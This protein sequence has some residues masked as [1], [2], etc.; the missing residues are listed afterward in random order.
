MKTTADAIDRLCTNL[1][2]M[3]VFLGVMLLGVIWAIVDWGPGVQ[4][5]INGE[6]ITAWRASSP[7]A[8]SSQPTAQGWGTAPKGGAE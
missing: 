5:N 6:T 1:W 7:P 3:T 8:D 4:L 2:W